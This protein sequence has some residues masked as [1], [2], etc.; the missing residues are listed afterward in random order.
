VYLNT[1]A[2]TTSVVLLHQNDRFWL[3]LSDTFS[4]L[5]DQFLSLITARSKPFSRLR[6][7]SLLAPHNRSLI[8]P[9]HHSHHSLLSFNEI[10]L[11]MAGASAEGK[12]KGKGKGSD[13]VDNDL[14]LRD[15]VM[16]SI[17]PLLTNFCS[18]HF[19]ITESTKEYDSWGKG[20]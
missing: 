2:P 15:F 14:E 9:R 17:I 16:A 18:R 7:D 12:E 10:E 13:E 19:T 20:S 5:I 6:T 8:H 4:N 3:L 11:L 1:E